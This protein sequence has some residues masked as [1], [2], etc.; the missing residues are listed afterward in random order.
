MKLSPI[1]K[2]LFIADLQ[3]LLQSEHIYKMNLYIQHGKTTTFTHCLVVAYYSYW[4]SLHLPFHLDRKSVARGALLHDFY[5]YDWHIPHESHRLHGFYHPGF[6][7]KNAKRYFNLNDTETDI[8]K[9][10]MWPLTLTSMPHNREAA[11][12]CIVDKIC[13][14]AE[15]LHISILPKDYPRLKKTVLKM[16]RTQTILPSLS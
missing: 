9:N 4:L 11:L 15:T 10:H 8:I 12:V 5:L 13:S 2:M 14:L 16:R 6:A 3:D 7:L 1:E